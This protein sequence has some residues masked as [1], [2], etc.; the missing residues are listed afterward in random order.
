MDIFKKN[1]KEAFRVINDV[2]L[3]MLSLFKSPLNKEKF[4]SLTGSDTTHFNSLINLLNSLRKYEPKTEVIVINLGL[5]ENEINHLKENFRYEIK[6]FDF[7]NN[8]DFLST[9]DEYNKLGHYAWKPISIYT[10]FK[11]TEKNI[12]WL[13]AGCLINKE[14]S[15][16]KFIINKNGFYSPQSSDNIEKWTHK[17]TL[18]LLKAPN[19]ILKKRNVSGGI[20]GFAKKSYQIEELL[21][22]WYKNSINEKII[23]PSGSSRLNHRQDQAILSVLIHKFNLSG[24]TPRTHRI[25]G[26]LKHQDD[27]K[28]NYLQ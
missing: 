19:S 6:N 13:D 28:D 17:Q 8:P 5:S 27:E 3:I 15:L 25:F 22:T 24:A 20:L 23:A 11:N 2:F 18:K 16:L 12:L 26:I 1:L 4:L 21:T 14:L 9:R 7:K 10:E